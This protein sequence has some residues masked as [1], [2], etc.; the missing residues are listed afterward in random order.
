MNNTTKT[1]LMAVVMLASCVVVTASTSVDAEDA[2]TPVASV[3]GNEYTE[4]AKAFEAAFKNDDSGPVTI[5]LLRNYTGPGIKVPSGSDIIFDFNGYTYVNE[6]GVG[7]SNTETNGFQLLRDSTIVFRDGTLTATNS[8]GCKILIQNY[9]NLT[10]DNMV[11]NSSATSDY[12]VSNN[13][14]SLTLDNGTVLNAK[15]GGYAFDLYY[16]PNGGYSGGI[17]V[18]VLDAVIN[19]DIQ[20]GTDGSSATT[21]YFYKTVMEFRGGTL[22]GSIQLNQMP[23][24]GAANITITGGTFSDDV[25]EYVADGY[26]IVDGTV[27]DEDYIEDDVPPVNWG[28]DDDDYVPPI[29]IPEQNGDSDDDATTIV[30]CAAAAVVAA[31]IAAYLIIDRR[32]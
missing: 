16:W 5:E 12:L 6:G 7:S 18:T 13:N 32:H 22:S 15:D 14:G 17:T 2:G 8:S 31:L 29:Y 3:G 19:G 9:S 21:D 4:M 30:A 25:S 11:L 23:F 20:Y 26:K 28:D 10:L 24:D 1:V 27:V